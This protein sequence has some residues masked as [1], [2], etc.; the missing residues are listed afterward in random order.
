MSFAIRFAVARADLLERGSR[1]H[2]RAQILSVNAVEI[3]SIGE[4]VQIDSGG[5]DLA[6]IHS[7]LFQIIQLVAHG[8]AQLGGG[9]GGV[10]S[11][12]WS[13]DE[14]ALGRTI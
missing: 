10:D 2:D 1:G 3:F 5:H 4:I 7:S 12:V 13:R 14:A 6:E 9:G 8:L 11:A